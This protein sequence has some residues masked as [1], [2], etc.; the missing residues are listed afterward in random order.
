M[1]KCHQRETNEVKEK[2]ADIS[3]LHLLPS[4]EKELVHGVFGYD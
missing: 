2:E 4:T 3:G 1:Y